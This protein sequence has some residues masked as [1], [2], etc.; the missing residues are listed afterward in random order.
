MVMQL[1]HP[2]TVLLIEDDVAIQEV[3]TLLLEEEGYSVITAANGQEG[4]CYLQTHPA[5]ALILLDLMMPGVD[6][7]DFRA[8]QLQDTALAQIPVVVLS[9]VKDYDVVAA[10]LGAVGCLGKPFLVQ[11][12]YEVVA[13]TI[14]SDLADSV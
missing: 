13:R 9:A 11:E 6:G 5:P 14:N 3:V 4:L 12:L 7:W 8:A 1:P 10:G 2:R